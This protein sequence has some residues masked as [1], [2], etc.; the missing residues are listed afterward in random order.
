M[1]SSPRLEC[2][3]LEN[4]TRYGWQLID[5]SVEI[6]WDAPLT[7]TERSPDTVIDSLDSDTSSDK[8][9]QEENEPSESVPQTDVNEY[10][11]DSDYEM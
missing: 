5:S 9:D 11:S 7:T 2:T 4:F 6:V 1:Y 10:G 8:S 3:D